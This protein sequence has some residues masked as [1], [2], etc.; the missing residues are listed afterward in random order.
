MKKIILLFCILML[1]MPSFAKGLKYVTYLP[2]KPYEK[3]I[4][5]ELLET[6]TI[7]QD[8]VKI[9]R[10]R[11]KPDKAKRLGNA[12]EYI[13]YNNTNKP[14]TLIS[15]KSDDFMTYKDACKKVDNVAIKDWQYWVPGYNIAWCIQY[16]KE[17]RM[18]IRELPENMEV[19]GLLGIIL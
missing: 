8:N 10:N 1:G 11:Y 18:F 12:Y 5:L 19:A 3:E 9:V 14:L 13:I 16:E 17:A 7:E 15:I 6:E 4:K 2:Y